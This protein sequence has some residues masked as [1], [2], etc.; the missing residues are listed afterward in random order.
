VN[1]FRSWRRWSPAAAFI[2]L[3]GGWYVA[4][5]FAIA[6]VRRT[7][8]EA[9]AKIVAVGHQPVFTDI[10]SIWSW[11]DSLRSELLGLIGAALIAVLLRRTSRWPLFLLAAALPIVIGRSEHL[12][13]WWAPGF[14]IDIWTFGAGVG[15]PG[16]DLSNFNAGPSWTLAGGTVLALAAVVVPALLA[17]PRAVADPRRLLRAVPYAAL[18]AVGTALAIGELKIDDTGGGADH[19]M[20]V[21]AGAAGLI[22]LLVTCVAGDDRYWRD[23]LV[24]AAA[25]GLLTVS[26]LNPSAMTTTK[27]AAFGAAAG[28]AAI[29]AAI[30]PRLATSSDEHRRLGRLQR[31]A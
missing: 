30:P 3:A 26:G 5:L 18:L 22:A 8:H 25:V 28:I 1:T 20:L 24:T 27:W 14:G 10:P 31:S 12:H 2:L 21:G 4:N 6:A 16:L 15:I 7:Q 9:N 29:A 23:V 11:S 19:N 17:Q 13:G